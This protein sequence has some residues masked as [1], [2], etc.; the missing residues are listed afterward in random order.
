[1]AGEYARCRAEGTFEALKM[2]DFME[3][4]DN[5]RKF[6]KR[7]NYQKDPNYTRRTLTSR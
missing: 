6:L 4:N 2:V 3:A 5:D 7:Q 1:M